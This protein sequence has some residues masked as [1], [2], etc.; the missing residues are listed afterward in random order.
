[1]KNRLQPVPSLIIL[2]YA[3]ILISGRTFHQHLCKVSD[4]D[5]CE[6]VEAN[7]HHHVSFKANSLDCPLQSSYDI[8]VN[9][10][11]DNGTTPDDGLSDCWTCCTLSQAGNSSADF[12]F[13]AN[14]LGVFFFCSDYENRRLQA[15]T[16]NYLVRGPPEIHSATS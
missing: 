16:H 10:P 1:M 6:H 8:T 5:C 15:C 9:S 2:A 13:F 3:G 4:T 12:F 14:N 11:R 7:T